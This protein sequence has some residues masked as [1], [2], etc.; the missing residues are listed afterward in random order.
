MQDKQQLI[1]LAFVLIVGL[2]G[3]YMIAQHVGHASDSHRDMHEKEHGL[4]EYDDRNDGVM[5]MP[6][7]AGHTPDPQ[8]NGN[9]P[10]E[11]KVQVQ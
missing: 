8:M 2:L 10:L 3:G 11:E 4:G 1:T 9:M 6:A 5:P 7:P